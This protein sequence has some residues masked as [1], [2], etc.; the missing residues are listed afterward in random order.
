MD[1]ALHTH[2]II[3]LLRLVATNAC[4]THLYGIALSFNNQIPVFDINKISIPH[5]GRRVQAA[6]KSNQLAD[7][8]ERVVFVRECVAHYELI[9]PRPTEEQYTRIAQE[10]LKKYPCLKDNG[11][12]YW[13]I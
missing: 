11:T 2:R 10:I 4:V 5:F 9:L 13:V 3:V 12:N 8:N 6:I 7:H 1:I